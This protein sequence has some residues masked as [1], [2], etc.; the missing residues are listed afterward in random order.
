MR[1]DHDS[2]AGYARDGAR[3]GYGGLADRFHRRATMR[4]HLQSEADIR[5]FYVDRRNHAQ[6]DDRPS[7]RRVDHLT[8]RGDDVFFGKVAPA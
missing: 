6:V 3:R 2:R 8:E 1:R 7:L 5:L 4:G